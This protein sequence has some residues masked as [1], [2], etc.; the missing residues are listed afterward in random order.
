V[1][2][3]SGSQNRKPELM[4]FALT[5]QLISSMVITMPALRPRSG[6]PLFP[7]AVQSIHTK[8]TEVHQEGEGNHVKN[9]RQSC[10][11]DLDRNVDISS[12][13]NRFSF[14]VESRGWRH[15]QLQHK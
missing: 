8:F 4:K 15:V 3:I 5:S 2:T 10:V 9:V 6:S 14:L 11:S 13:G 7:R 12:S 1:T